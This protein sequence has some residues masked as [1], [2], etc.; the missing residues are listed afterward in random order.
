MKHKLIKYNLTALVAVGVLSLT[1]IS[2]LAAELAGTV[3]GAKQPIAGST[4]TLFAAGAGAVACV[5]AGG[6]KVV[7]GGRHRLRQQARDTFNAAV[8]R[9]VA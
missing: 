8:R 3:Q 7:E 2:A 4:G 9:L 5:W 6:N 1:N